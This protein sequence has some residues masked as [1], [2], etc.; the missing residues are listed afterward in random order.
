MSKSEATFCATRLVLKSPLLYFKFVPMLRIITFARAQGAGARSARAIG[1]IES[2][3]LQ[4]RNITTAGDTTAT[5]HTVEKGTDAASPGAV[6]HQGSRNFVPS[7]PSSMAK[8]KTLTKP[9]PKHPKRPSNPPLSIQTLDPSKLQASDFLDLTKTSGGVRIDMPNSTFNYLEF[10]HRVPTVNG[11]KGKA[12]A[13]SFPRVAR[14]FFYFKP[15]PPGEPLET[16]EVRF[17]K[18]AND[19]PESFANG[20]DLKV[21]DRTWRLTF[22]KI[23]HGRNLG[24][25]GLVLSDGLEETEAWKSYEK[26]FREQIYSPAPVIKPARPVQT[27][28]P[29]K[30]LSSDWL[31]LSRLS[32]AT[33]DVKGAQVQLTYFK[34]RFPDN[35]SGFLYYHSSPGA[36]HFNGDVRFRVTP[37][38][39]P[40]SFASGHDLE[41]NMTPWR[42]TLANI[43]VNDK[44]AAGFQGL[45]TSSNIVSPTVLDAFKQ[46]LITEASTR[47][48]TGL[49][50]GTQYIHGLEQNFLVRFDKPTQGLFVVGKDAIQRVSSYD[51][52]AF[53]DSEQ[54]VAESGQQFR[55]WSGSA[56]C[57]LERS[58]HD[59]NTVVMRVVQLT[60]PPVAPEDYK[61][62]PIPQEGELVR[63]QSGEAWTFAAEDGSALR[64]LQENA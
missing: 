4:R 54:P 45:I 19:K 11:I 38:K 50:P 13:I 28:D 53:V 24:L 34:R 16:G 49:H 2:R 29:T 17:R 5:A 1:H 56:Y 40:S 64:L 52:D 55:P 46:M 26:E 48:G 6:G 25:K 30:L 14:G 12:K 57:R 37:S 32:T 10:T 43:A 27:L 41:F 51:L 22:K 36:S 8:P 44:D 47:P 39:D 61:G 9:K 42:R 58:A 31:D 63:L 35:T 33:V 18:T 59:A 20:E 15:A 21:G 60:S 23:F 7:P 62:L 3:G